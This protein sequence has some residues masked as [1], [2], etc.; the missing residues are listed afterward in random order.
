M[1]GCKMQL[2]KENN[3][4]VGGKRGQKSVGISIIAMG[5]EVK[6]RK[7]RITAKLCWKKK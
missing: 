4:Q 6:N 1:L 2:E 7:S 3:P 5:P